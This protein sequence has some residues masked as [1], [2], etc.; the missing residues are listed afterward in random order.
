MV[1]PGA[2]GKLIHGTVPLNVQGNI[3]ELVAITGYCCQ[4]SAA[5]F[6]SYQHP[7]RTLAERKQPAK[8]SFSSI[9]V[10]T[11]LFNVVL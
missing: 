8:Y 7:F 10:A 4:C 2:W 1:Y 6:E 3:R 11:K 9:S 5:G